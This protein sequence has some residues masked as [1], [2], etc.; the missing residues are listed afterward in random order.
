[1]TQIDR[2]AL[3]RAGSCILA[4]ARLVMLEAGSKVTVS[5]LLTA[6]GHI[7]GEAKM[8]VDEFVAMAERMLNLL[9]D[10]GDGYEYVIDIQ[11]IET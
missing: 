10:L 4:E 6:A 3:S 5:C 2:G 1:M 7:A 8:D 11:E 9:V